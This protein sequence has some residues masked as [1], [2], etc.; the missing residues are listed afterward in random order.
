MNPQS[1]DLQYPDGLRPHHAEK[2]RG[3]RRYTGWLSLVVL[4]ALMGVA[5]AGLLGGG[6]P[7]RTEIEAPEA[8]LAVTT[9]RILRSGMFFETRVD[10]V[11]RRDL[12]DAVLAFSETLWRNMTI[13]TVIPQA[14]E[15]Q[16]EAGAFRMSYGKLPAGGHIE[17]KIDGQIN[18][19]LFA[20]TRGAITLLDGRREIGRLPVSIRV[21]P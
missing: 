16:F 6:P 2:A 15:E 1:Q 21:L 12:D 4:G 10:V 19:P 17:V 7:Q 20:G 13:N 14:G 11:A 9:P 18:P 8:T 5:A 3:F